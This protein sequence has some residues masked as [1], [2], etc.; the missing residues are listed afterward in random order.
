MNA[1]GTRVRDLINRDIKTI[2]KTTDLIAAV[3][4]MRNLD[5]SQVMNKRCQLQFLRP[6]SI[7]AAYQML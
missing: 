6:K 7:A 3:E 4:M 2:S 5:I 1:K